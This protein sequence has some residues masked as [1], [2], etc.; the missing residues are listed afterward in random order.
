MELT[1]FSHSTMYIYISKHHDVH[2]K[3]NLVNIKRKKAEGLLEARTS[4]GNTV[5]PPSLKGG[6]ERK[7]ERRRRMRKEGGGWEAEKKDRE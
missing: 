6:R 5:R 1:S 3:Y 7:T 2:H 4:L